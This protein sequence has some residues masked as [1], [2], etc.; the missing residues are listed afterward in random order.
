MPLLASPNL[1]A[2]EP[3]LSAWE[4]G[5]SEAFTCPELRSWQ[6]ASD[7]ETPALT[8]VNGT[9]MARQ[10]WTAPWLMA[11]RA[12][13]EPSPDEPSQDSCSFQVAS[14]VRLGTQRAHAVV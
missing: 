4:L 6:S 10:S 9:L 5:P 3:A 1:P 11:L 12:S 13:A 14:W 7:R 2:R 8:G